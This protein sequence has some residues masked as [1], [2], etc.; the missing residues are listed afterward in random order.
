MI[1]NWLCPYAPLSRGSCVTGMPRERIDVRHLQAQR[2]PASFKCGAT[3]VVGGHEGELDALTV[4]Q[5]KYMG[6]S[7]VTL[8]LSLSP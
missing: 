7:K 2:Q 5:A 3:G 8:E 1:Q 4:A 6:A